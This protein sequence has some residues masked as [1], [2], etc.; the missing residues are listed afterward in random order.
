[1]YFLAPPHF[2]TPNF[3]LFPYA[4]KITTPQ[5]LPTLLFKN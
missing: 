1:M 4:K 3:F 5:S 2:F